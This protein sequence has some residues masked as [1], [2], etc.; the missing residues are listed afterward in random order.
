MTIPNRPPISDCEI[1]AVV[2]RSFHCAN[3]I[4]VGETFVFDIEG[5]LLPHRSSANLCLGIVAKL[6]PA[7]LLAQDRIAEGLHPISA[8][9]H[10]FDCFDTG[11]DHGG[12]GK[13]YVEM[14]LVDPRT[15]ERV[16]PWPQSE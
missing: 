3:H 1:H 13:V 5:R 14:V 8:N 15:G 7:L 10:T 12:T 6:Q 4:R 11:I 9:F 2:T 16:E